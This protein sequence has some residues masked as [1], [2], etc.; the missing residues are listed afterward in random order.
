[1]YRTYPE[2]GKYKVNSQKNPKKLL[3]LNPRFK[4]ITIDLI[5][6]A[7]CLCDDSSNTYAV[8]HMV[9]SINCADLI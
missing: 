8:S 6:L 5:E 2:F 3:R 7:K 9:F 4:N 1:M